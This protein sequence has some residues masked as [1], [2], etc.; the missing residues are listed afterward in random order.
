MTVAYSTAAYNRAMSK[1]LSEVA[2]DLVAQMRPLDGEDAI[3]MSAE[4]RE[5]YKSECYRAVLIVWPMFG[6]MGR[7]CFD[8]WWA[9]NDLNHMPQMHL[10]ANDG[11]AHDGGSADERR[12]ALGQ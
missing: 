5:R 4:L 6:Y 12:K 8:C 3:T 9:N 11:C 10:L 1:A 7:P 2:P